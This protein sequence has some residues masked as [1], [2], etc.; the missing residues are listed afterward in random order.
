MI[1][2]VVIDAGHGGKDPGGTGNGLKEKDLVENTTEPQVP[3]KVEP[4]IESDI[5]Q[6]E[7]TVEEPTLF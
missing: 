3:A 4:T 1:K 6:D 2:T 7:E 5:E